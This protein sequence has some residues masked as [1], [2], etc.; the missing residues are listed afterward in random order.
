M[1]LLT[2]NNVRERLENQLLLD[3]TSI[4]LQTTHN[5]DLPSSLEIKVSG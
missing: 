5:L 2:S 3:A 4:V 1:Q